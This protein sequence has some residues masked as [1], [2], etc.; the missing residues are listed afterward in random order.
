[1]LLINN[2]KHVVLFMVDRLWRSLIK[3]FYEWLIFEE[4]EYQPE[5]LYFSP[6]EANALTK[7]ELLEWAYGIRDN[8]IDKRVGFCKS[9]RKIGQEIYDLGEEKDREIGKGLVGLSDS[10]IEELQKQFDALTLLILGVEENDSDKTNEAYQILKETEE[11]IRTLMSN[12]A[13]VFNEL[14]KRGFDVPD[15]LL[16]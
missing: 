9:I 6:Y 1:M 10:I 5:T 2:C 12:F 8:L 16:L 3:N 11:K 15:K 4:K 14:A 7:D 13:Y